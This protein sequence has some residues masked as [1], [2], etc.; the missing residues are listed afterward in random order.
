MD[1]NSLGHQKIP[2]Y[3]GD[4]V[5]AL[6]IGAVVLGLVGI[7]VVGNLLPLSTGFDIVAGIILIGIAGLI[8]PHSPFV[9]GVS[10]VASSFAAF[11]F[12]YAAVTL[13]AS[14]TTLLLIGRQVEAVI[15]V[16][17]LYFSIKTL[18]AMTQNKT[19]E[20]EPPWEF[21]DEHKKV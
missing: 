9:V 1:Y 14:D 17:A 12:E 5:R 13:S 15:F 6:F 4:T 11:L 8:N 3:Y 10:I 19:G 7:P 21:E 18:R 16:T 2:H 20:V